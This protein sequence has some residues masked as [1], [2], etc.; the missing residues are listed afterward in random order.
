VDLT[1][2]TAGADRQAG[3]YTGHLLTVTVKGTTF[4]VDDFLYRTS[5]MVTRDRGGRLRITGRL[6]G[7]GKVDLQRNQDGANG[8]VQ[9]IVEVI[10]ASSGGAS[11]TSTAGGAG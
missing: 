11:S 1:A 4:D 8:T 10:A 7:Y 6:V 3:G 9:A 5:H 2:V